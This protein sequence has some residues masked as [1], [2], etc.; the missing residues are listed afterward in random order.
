MI[1]YCGHGHANDGAWV[2]YK[3][4]DSSEKNEYLITNEVLDMF[5]EKNWTKSIEITSESCFS[6]Y[7][8]KNAKEWIDEKRY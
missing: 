1:Y 5:T 4:D 7:F 6:G 3:L 2:C 8:C